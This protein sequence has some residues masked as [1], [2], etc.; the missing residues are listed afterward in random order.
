MLKSH[1]EPDLYISIAFGKWYRPASQVSVSLTGE[2][3][4]NTRGIKITR[5]KRVIP[6][7]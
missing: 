4:H 2:N 5:T 3:G 1:A 7:I 6:P